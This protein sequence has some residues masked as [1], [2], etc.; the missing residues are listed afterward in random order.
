MTFVGVKIRV[1]VYFHAQTM[2][3]LLSGR[4]QTP[5]LN[6]KLICFYNTIDESTVKLIDRLNRP[7]LAS[8]DLSLAF[9]ARFRSGFGLAQA[10]VT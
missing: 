5:K 6:C 3:I 10:H 8:A 7:G 4:D 9:L 1:T 2:V